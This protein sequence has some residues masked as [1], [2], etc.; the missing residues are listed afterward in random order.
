MRGYLAAAQPPVRASD[1]SV[2]EIID[3]PTPKQT[4]AVAVATPTAPAGV[5][6]P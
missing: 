3:L 6:P 1:Q 4:A 5:G 2:L